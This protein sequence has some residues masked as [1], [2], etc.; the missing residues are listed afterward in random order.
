M[1]AKSVF[2]SDPQVLQRHPKTC[3]ISDRPE[4]LQSTVALVFVF[5][6]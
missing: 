1:S 3:I 5:E 4:S 6:P 2:E